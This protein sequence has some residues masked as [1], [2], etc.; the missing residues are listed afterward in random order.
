MYNWNAWEYTREPLPI[1]W[2]TP[3]WMDKRHVE[4][5]YDIIMASKFRTLLE[6]GCHTGCS[7]SAIIQA[8]KDG[9]KTE[10]HLCDPD[11]NEIL[12]KMIGETKI[13][14]HMNDSLRVIP[15]REWDLVIVD[16]D[17]SLKQVSRELG[18]LLYYEVPTI[19]A[20]DVTYPSCDGAVYLSEALRV[21]P[22]YKCAI[23][24]MKRENEYTH[25]GL[26]YASRYDLNL[27]IWSKHV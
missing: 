8:L 23:D 7:T 25:R 24:S 15:Q 10:V 22:D 3:W 2:P 6:I 5:I 17:H 20:H 26:L 19:I 21:H 4:F 18:L 27:E 11:D 13:T 1:G 9:C 14:R 16:G 12:K